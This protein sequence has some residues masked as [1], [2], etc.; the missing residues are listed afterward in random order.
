MNGL[1]LGVKKHKDMYIYKNIK[2]SQTILE[3]SNP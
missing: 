1:N 2:L 3:N